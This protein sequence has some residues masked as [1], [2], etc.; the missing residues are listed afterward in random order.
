MHYI[1]CAGANAA[2]ALTEL[3]VFDCRYAV[4]TLTPHSEDQTAPPGSTE[5]AAQTDTYTYADGV[6]TDTSTGADML[7]RGDSLS[8]DNGLLQLNFSRATGR[9]TSLTNHQAGVATN[10]TLD[11]AAYLSGKLPDNVRFTNKLSHSVDAIHGETAC[12]QL[13]EPF[14]LACMWEIA[15]VSWCV[16]ALVRA[17]LRVH[18]CTRSSVGLQG[19]NFFALC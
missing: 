15:C 1:R 12:C 10:L 3:P 16:C 17:G 9:L 7:P 5:A 8:L 18:L 6:L 2:T 11:M 14:I 4:Y 13:H 19:F